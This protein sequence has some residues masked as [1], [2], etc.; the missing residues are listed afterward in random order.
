[1]LK[2]DFCN[3]SDAYVVMK[4]TIVTDPGD[5]KRNESVAFKNNAPLMKTVSAEKN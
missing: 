4:G 1:M 2:S 5:A 3:F